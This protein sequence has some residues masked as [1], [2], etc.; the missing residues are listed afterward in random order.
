MDLVVTHNAFNPE[1]QAILNYCR[2]SLN[3]ITISDI[4]NTAGT[5]LIPGVEWGELEQF[6]STSNDHQTN[7]PRPAV[8]FWIYWQ[9]LLHIIALPDGTFRTP[10]GPW[11]HDGSVLRR[12]WNAYFD[13][14]YKFLFRKTSAGW[15]QYELFDTRFING[16]HRDWNPSMTSV[17]VSI[18]EL[19]KDCWQLT[20]PPAIPH[21]P[22][23]VMIPPT[24]HDYI[25]Q[26][27]PWEHHLFADLTL[28]FDPY[29]ILQ[30]I[31]HRPLTIADALSPPMTDSEE[32]LIVSD[33][34]KSTLKMTFGWALCL[35]D[36]TRL[37]Y[38]AGPSYRWGSSHR[39]EATGMLS[40][41][42]FLHHLTIYCAQ[43]ILRPTNFTS[44]NK[45]LLTRVTQRSQYTHKYPTATHAPDWDLIEALHDPLAHF[46]QPTPFTHVLGHQDDTKK[47]HDL[48]LDAQLNVDA[49]HEAGNYQWNYPVT[50]RDKVPMTAITRVHFHLQQCTITGHYRH[51][52]R[53][54]AS[55]DDFFQK[56]REIHEWTPATFALIHLPTLRSAVHNNPNRLIHTFK[57]LHGVLPTQ[58]IKAAWYGSNPCCPVCLDDDTQA[59]FVHCCHPT[60]QAWRNTLLRTTRTK[61]ATLHTPHELQVVFLEAIEAWLDGER[62]DPRGYPRIYRAAL[63]A[64]NLIG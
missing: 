32:V 39:A 54:A 64:Q 25:A 27:P 61:L 63:T 3:A 43:P 56:C 14:R 48:P 34:S 41:E 44:D 5:H 62:I 30:L 1:I 9:R 35:S 20:H 51:H 12:T 21:H 47:Y 59:H 50:V 7:Q 8:F 40:G 57:F 53:T 19:S 60:A 37:A 22:N 17:P 55:Q 29:A 49:D 28:L 26:L 23:P 24:F 45:G 18:E 11:I 58:E 10:L 52:I 42:H 4:S 16:I 15:T 36:G 6:P 33:G 2:L 13:T 46:T 31:N 38:C